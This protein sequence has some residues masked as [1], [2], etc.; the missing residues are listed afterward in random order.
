MSLYELISKEKINEVCKPEEGEKTCK[1]LVVGSHGY[2]CEKLTE[3]GLFI[4]ESTEM[5]SKSDRCNGIDHSLV[6]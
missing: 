1:Y 5:V 4:G 3:I 6:L 2:C